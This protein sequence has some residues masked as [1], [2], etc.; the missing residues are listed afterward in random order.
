VAIHESFS[1][2]CRDLFNL[3]GAQYGAAPRV[4][5]LR[6]RIKLE[7]E[8]IHQLGEAG[9]LDWLVDQNTLVITGLR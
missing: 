5:V 2:E 7:I 4:H 1:D 3:V 6:A 8:R 9:K